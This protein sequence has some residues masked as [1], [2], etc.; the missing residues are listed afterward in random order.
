VRSFVDQ[1]RFD[2]ARRIATT[3]LEG[4]AGS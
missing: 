4:D 2:E 3:V 1:A